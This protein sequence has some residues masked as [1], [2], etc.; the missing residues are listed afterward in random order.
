MAAFPFGPLDRH[1]RN[2][3]TAL[4]ASSFHV[5]RRRVSRETPETPYSVTGGSLGFS[6]LL[7]DPIAATQ[8]GRT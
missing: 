5:K 7:H 6:R 1:G 8:K 4:T 3:L 2:A